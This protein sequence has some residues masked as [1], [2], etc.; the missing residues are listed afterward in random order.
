MST[1][2]DPDRYLGGH[3]LVYLPKYVTPDDPLFDESD[4]DIIR[5]FVPYLR[6]MHPTLSDDDIRCARVSRVRH[7]L[8]VTTLDYSAHEPP[9]RTSVPGL[10]LVSSANIV[11][12]TLNVDE[13]VQL[14][15]RAV[16]MLE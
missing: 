1:L 16:A 6:S 11:N 12:G 8:A 7:V 5:S 4:D 9:M 13:S 10:Y 3:S 2:V 14:A 15:D